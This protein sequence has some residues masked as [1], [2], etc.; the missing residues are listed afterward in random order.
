[1]LILLP[2]LLKHR[3]GDR[4]VWNFT[5]LDGLSK[6]DLLSLLGNSRNAN[7]RVCTCTDC[8][9]RIAWTAFTERRVVSSSTRNGHGPRG[10][11]AKSWV[12]VDD[13][14]YKP[15][16]HEV[17]YSGQKKEEKRVTGRWLLNSHCLNFILPFR[18]VRTLLGHASAVANIYGQKMHLI[19]SPLCEKSSIWWTVLC[20][21]IVYCL[22]LIL[23]PLIIVGTMSD[24]NMFSAHLSVISPR[25][26]P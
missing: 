6:V 25:K 5:I 20:L 1:M 13:L 8:G 4:N 2:L 23:L 22:M 7:I 3:I 17:L 21:G 18:I 12:Q 10:Q 14:N 15:A 19:A 11:Q 24:Q 26:Y 9:C 16:D